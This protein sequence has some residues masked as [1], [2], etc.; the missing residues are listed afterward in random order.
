VCQQGGFC[1]DAKWKYLVSADGCVAQTRLVKEGGLWGKGGDN[2][3]PE[4]ETGG[5]VHVLKD[6]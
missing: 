4:A 2:L 6:D 3:R 1:D 5:L